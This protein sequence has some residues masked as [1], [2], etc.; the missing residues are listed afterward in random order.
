MNRAFRHALG[1]A[2][3]FSSNSGTKLDGIVRSR[4]GFGSF[5]SAA[6]E[7]L[8]ADDSLLPADQ[9]YTL[10]E[11]I[12]HKW[13]PVLS[14]SSLGLPLRG[15]VYSLDSSWTFLNHGAFGAV[16]KPMAETAELLRQ[17]CENQPLKYFDRDLFPM[18]AYSLQ[19]AA[20][21]LNCPPQELYPLQNVTAGLNC[22]MQSIHLS[23]GD[24]VVCFSLTYGSTKKM[25]QDLCNRSGATLRIAPV[26][27]PVRDEQSVVDSLRNTLT[28][29]T[30]L[31]I[32]D[33]ITSNTGL[34]LP[35]LELAALAKATGALV[36]VDAAHAMMSTHVSL[37]PLVPHSDGDGTLAVSG[38]AHR[39]SRYLSE[40][41]DIWII[42]AHKWFS[43]PK[44][45]A[46]MW[47]RP[48]VA[49]HLRPPIVSHGFAPY[50]GNANDR[51][52]DMPNVRW[53]HETC[54]R[55]SPAQIQDG[56][57]WPVKSNL[58]SALVWDGCRDYSPILSL[59]VGL[60]IWDAIGINARSEDGTDT[61]GM[62]VCRAYMRDLLHNQVV[63][64][65][66]QDWELSDDD[67]PAPRSMRENSP[68]ALVSRRGW[69]CYRIANW[70]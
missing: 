44:G 21:L 16:M 50:A 12:I 65:L 9:L 62:Q 3:L 43:G 45:C 32:I 51:C 56:G 58:L 19:Q 48:S 64:M 34:T 53:W 26:P 29:K 70:R 67:L 69:S 13:R 60:R 36:V 6:I 52:I 57:T 22:V 2:R 40:V 5:H 41:A 17:E 24:E 25:L 68:M 49:A 23:E 30:R 27:L 15:K 14:N 42:N 20:K 54:P 31:V 46:L 18:I 11:S 33:Q 63:P 47:V 35:V 7:E 28:N 59:P 1:G 55:S 4:Q 66:Q 8:V 37:Y 10:N 38:S 39:P 61:G